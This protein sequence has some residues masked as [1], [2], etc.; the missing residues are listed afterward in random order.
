M[1]EKKLMT[2]RLSSYFFSTSVFLTLNFACVLEFSL[3]A[4]KG[5]KFYCLL[6]QIII[7]GVIGILKKRKLVLER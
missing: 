2:K 3:L 4:P 7:V 5:I 1:N 6:L